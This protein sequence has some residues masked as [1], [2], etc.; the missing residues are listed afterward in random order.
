MGR[1][2]VQVNR[3]GRVTLPAAARRALGIGDGS[4][5]AV[6]VERGALRLEPVDLVLAEDRGLYTAESIASIKRA[7]ADVRAGRVYDISLADLEAGRYP[8]RKRAR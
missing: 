3:Q 8:R 5:L 2:L 6:K 1:T 4:Q 7:L